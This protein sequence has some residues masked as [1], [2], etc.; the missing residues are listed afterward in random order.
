MKVHFK[1]R[2]S[3]VKNYQRDITSEIEYSE[4]VPMH[5]PDASKMEYSFSSRDDENKKISIYAYFST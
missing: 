3:T 4:C 2:G 1:G 5:F